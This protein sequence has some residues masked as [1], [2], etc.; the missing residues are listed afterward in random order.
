MRRETVIPRYRICLCFAMHTVHSRVVTRLKSVSVLSASPTRIAQPTT[1]ETVH[2]SD[3]RLPLLG[4]SLT[5]LLLLLLLFLLVSAVNSGLAFQLVEDA[6]E[7]LHVARVAV[8]TFV[9][10]SLIGYVVCVVIGS[11]DVCHFVKEGL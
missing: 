2:R 3:V 4:C 9:N 6:F 8:H 10:A 7:L 11:V 5:L 1:E